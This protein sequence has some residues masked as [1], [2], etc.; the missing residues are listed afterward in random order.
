LHWSRTLLFSPVERDVF[1]AEDARRHVLVFILQVGMCWY[2]RLRD[3]AVSVNGKSVSTEAAAD[4][5]FTS[6]TSDVGN[7]GEGSAVRANGG[8][9]RKSQRAATTAFKVVR[10]IN[11]LPRATT[12]AVDTARCPSG[13][14]LGARAAAD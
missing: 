1:E 7:A 9:S 8:I 12:P 3:A 10:R 4:D 13:S 14:E 5:A 6:Q 11:A 2:L